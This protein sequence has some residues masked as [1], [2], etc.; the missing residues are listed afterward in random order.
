MLH[1][2][3]QWIADDTEIARA[4]GA[5]YTLTAS[6]QGKTIKV[7]V[8]FTDDAEN[9]E[10]LTSAATVAVAAA[11]PPGQLLSA[12][13]TVGTGPNFEGY[14]SFVAGSTVGT[15]SSDNFTLSN[16]NLHRKSPW[17]S[18]RH[19]DHG[20]RPECSQRAFNLELGGVTFRI[21]RR[22]DLVLDVRVSVSVERPR[23]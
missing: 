16:T 3:Y 9:A 18:E 11:P 1:N 10:S 20:G 23:A 14:S 8:S 7:K 17:S 6:E 21:L 5:S 19:V 12:T 15:L 2:E 22:D 13:M 4:T